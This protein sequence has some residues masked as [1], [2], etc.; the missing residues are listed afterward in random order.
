MFLGIRDYV[1]VMDLAEGHV[2]ALKK[3]QSKHVNLQV[4]IVK[5]LYFYYLT[6]ILI[7]YVSK[8]IYKNSKKVHGK[9]FYFKIC[10]GFN[11]P[12]NI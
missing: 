2:A 7:L 1:H 8:Q 11:A 12:N 6:L 3:L 4:N 10:I 9:L 5:L